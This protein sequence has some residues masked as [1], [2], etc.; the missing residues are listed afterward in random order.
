MT[1]TP[2][3]LTDGIKKYLTD[4]W[5][6]KEKTK[7]TKHAV[8]KVHEL[9]GLAGYQ[10]RGETF[11]YDVGVLIGEEENKDRESYLKNFISSSLSSRRGSLPAKIV[12]MV[13]TILPSAQLQYLHD[14]LPENTYN[15]DELRIRWFRTC[16]ADL[17]AKKEGKEIEIHTDIN[18]EFSLENLRNI[19]DKKATLTLELKDDIPSTYKFLLSRFSM[20]TFSKKIKKKANKKIDEIMEKS[21]FNAN[22]ILIVSYILGCVWGLQFSPTHTTF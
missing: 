18:P 16:W 20:K 17:R 5:T 22:L 3:R 8:S 10:G 15:Q 21:K 7:I 2:M 11:T 14:V 19:E 13:W 6:D 12:D 9:L 1:T 4:D